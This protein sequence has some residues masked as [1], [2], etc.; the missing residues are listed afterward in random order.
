MNTVAAFFDVDETLIN[1]KSMFHFY[2]YWCNEK[3]LNPQR[4]E[5]TRRFKQDVQEGK[6][7]ELLNQEYYQQFI[8]VSLAELVIFGQRWFLTCLNE[9]HFIESGL[10]ALRQH[11]QRGDTVVFVSGSMQPILQP[12]ADCLAVEHLLCAPLIINE[13]GYLTGGIGT[14]QT[15]GNGKKEA[16][17]AFCQQQGLQPA[18]CYAYGDDISD[19]PMLEATG[20]PVCVGE[21]PALLNYA[22]LRGWRTI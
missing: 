18:H 6:R 12:I 7:R 13:R 9:S 22:Q 10:S 19:V 20:H 1:L 5:Y 15:I 3:G 21:N 8:N 17:L 16:L 14:P 4:E 2:D 11:Q